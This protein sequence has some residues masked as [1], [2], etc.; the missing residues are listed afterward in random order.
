MQIAYEVAYFTNNPHELYLY[1]YIYSSWDII[2]PI[3]IK[4]IIITKF[5]LV[6]KDI[7]IYHEY[8]VKKKS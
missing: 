2:Y 8:S 4:C 3:K 1:I 6:Y 5:T 7:G